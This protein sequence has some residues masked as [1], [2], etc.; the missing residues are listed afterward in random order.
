M[1]STDHCYRFAVLTAGL[2][3]VLLS[4]CITAPPPPRGYVRVGSSYE[5]AMPQVRRIGV[6]T[7][8]AV[9]YDRSG[10]N[11]YPFVREWDRGHCGQAAQETQSK[12]RRGLRSRKPVSLVPKRRAGSFAGSSCVCVISSR[13]LGTWK[14]REGKLPSTKVKTGNESFRGLSIYPKKNR[15]GFALG[16]ETSAV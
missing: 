7:D 13:S 4:G 8:A 16:N 10:T 2:M 15:A 3:S 12:E 5:S 9:R 11:D 14:T 1:K 6:I